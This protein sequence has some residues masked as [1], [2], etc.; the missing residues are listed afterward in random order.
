M[1][2]QELCSC[3]SIWDI[4]KAG[5]QYMNKTSNDYFLWYSILL[6]H[7][8]ALRSKVL[9]LNYI[10]TQCTH[11]SL[12]LWLPKSLDLCPQTD[13][14]P[15]FSWR[16]F[17]RSSTAI[18]RTVNLL[19]W[20]VLCKATRPEAYLQNE[21]LTMDRLYLRGEN[22]AKTRI[23]NFRLSKISLRWNPPKV[24]VLTVNDWVAVKFGNVER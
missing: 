1:G 18:N 10:N 14:N 8:V 6:C 13:I 2:E 19:Q 12:S 11:M 23:F 17:P 16:S 20:Q 15:G 9:E 21:P 3:K 7:V 24:M 4:E 22:E 5:L